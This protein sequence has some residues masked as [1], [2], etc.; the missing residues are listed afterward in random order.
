MM[1]C[2]LYE[3][4]PSFLVSERR[5]VVAADSCGA[6]T[7]VHISSTIHVVIFLWI[8]SSD[9]DTVSWLEGGDDTAWLFG[10]KYSV[11]LWDEIARGLREKFC[12]DFY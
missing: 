3:Y 1:D 12:W 5:H 10:S 4:R 8:T 9:G 2:S 7:L 6:A 11:S